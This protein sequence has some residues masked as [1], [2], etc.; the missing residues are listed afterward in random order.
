M[1][2]VVERAD[3]ERQAHTLHRSEH[4]RRDRHVEAGRVLEQQRRPAAR[5]FARAVC[6]RRDLEVR[7]GRI[8]DVFEEPSLVEVREK[9]VQVGVQRVVRNEAR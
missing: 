4:V 8:G 2:Q 1:R 5:G 9:S 3:A 7:I 6:D